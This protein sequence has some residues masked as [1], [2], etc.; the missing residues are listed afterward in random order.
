MR[1][2]DLTYDLEIIGPAGTVLCRHQIECTNDAEAVQLAFGA[3]SPFGHRLF[4][5]G[6][7]IGGF[8]PGPRSPDLAHQSEDDCWEV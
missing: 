6:K 4:R 1:K 8:N 3:E 5:A 2:P 7:F